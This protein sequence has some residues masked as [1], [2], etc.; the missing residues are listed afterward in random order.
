MLSSGCFVFAYLEHVL[1]EMMI[2]RRVRDRNAAVETRTS[3]PLHQRSH[4]DWN[5]RLDRT[6]AGTVLKSLSG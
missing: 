2:R 4:D 3:Q 1:L 6:I 5:G